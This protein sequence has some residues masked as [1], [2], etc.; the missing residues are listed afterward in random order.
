[1]AAAAEVMHG[2]CP[3]RGGAERGREREGDRV[4]VVWMGLAVV[5]DDNRA[6]QEAGL[7]LGWG[8][9]LAFCARASLVTFDAMFDG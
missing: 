2:S 4:S 9:G 5:L 3:R 7:G 8:F 6:W 1:M